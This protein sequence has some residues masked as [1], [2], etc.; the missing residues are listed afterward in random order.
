MVVRPQHV[1]VFGGSREDEMSSDNR[2]ASESGEDEDG[3]RDSRLLGSRDRVDDRPRR[4]SII[5]YP[6]RRFNI[7]DPI[8]I[9][10]TI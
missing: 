9:L 2:R 4:D 3:E 6:R 8:M 1:R 5:R 7:N 10:R